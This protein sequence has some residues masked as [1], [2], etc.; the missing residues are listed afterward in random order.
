MELLDYVQEPNLKITLVLQFLT[1]QDDY[2]SLEEIENTVA[3]ALLKV[4]PSHIQPPQVF[5]Q[6]SVIMAKTSPYPIKKS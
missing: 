2:R 3:Q 6:P 4:W 1:E 5:H